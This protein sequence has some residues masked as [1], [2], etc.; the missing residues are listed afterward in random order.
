VNHPSPMEKS[1]DNTEVRILKKYI[2]D[3]YNL[4]TGCVV[5]LSIR[6]KGVGLL[7]TE[8]QERCSNILLSGMDQANMF[9]LY[10]EGKIA[11]DPGALKTFIT[12]V[13][14]KDDTFTKIAGDMCELIY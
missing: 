13:L 12:A 8:Q 14:Q 9:L 10:I 2:S 11:T 7:S 6:A 3:I 5:G 1:E 4:S